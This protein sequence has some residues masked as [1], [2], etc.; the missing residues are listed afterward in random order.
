MFARGG[1][2]VLQLEMVYDQ[3]RLFIVKLPLVCDIA[4]SD[5]ILKPVS[6]K[7]I[8]CAI[9]R[10][11]YVFFPILI[12]LLH[13]SLWGFTQVLSELEIIKVKG[14]HSTRA[15]GAVGPKTS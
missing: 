2:V 10:W 1:N 14:V 8:F 3:V 7:W 9:S 15:A 13:I 11:F 4:I 5:S 6:C 12:Y